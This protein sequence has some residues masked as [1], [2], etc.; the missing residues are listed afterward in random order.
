M[1][2][3]PRAVEDDALVQQ[4]A[5]GMVLLQSVSSRT[6]SA[7]SVWRDSSTRSTRRSPLAFPR[8]LH[9]PTLPATR[10]SN[11]IDGVLVDLGAN[12]G[13]VTLDWANRLPGRQIHAYEPNPATNRTLRVNVSANALASRVTVHG[14][15]VGCA[16]GE[17]TL[18][19]NPSSALSTGYGEETPSAG[20]AAIRVRTI[21]LDEVVKRGGQPVA[22]LKIDTEGA[23]ADI[24]EGAAEETLA[25]VRQL[26][27]EYHNQ[28]CPD[29][30]G[31]CLR[32]LGRAGFRCRIRPANAH[33]GLLYARR[34]MS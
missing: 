25:R 27:L 7:I 23:E 29:A 10:G 34:A 14:E 1:V 30:R 6:G 19:A 32:V 16:R 18:W 13:A 22:L 4:L 3:S 33:Q 15:F 12:I 26:V 2:R 28:L 20:S 21:D 17:R 11:Q 24:L 5:R 31:R 8:G 9:S